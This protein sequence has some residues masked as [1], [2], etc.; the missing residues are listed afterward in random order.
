MKRC[1]QCGGTKHSKEC[2]MATPPKRPAEEFEP[3]G[4]IYR[5]RD[6]GLVDVAVT[7]L[8]MIGGA[9]VGGALWRMFF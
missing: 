5:V 8:G 4:P 9:L 2:M 7:L 6:D 3:V 1:P